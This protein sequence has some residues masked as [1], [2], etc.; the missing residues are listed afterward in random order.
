MEI[1]A[2]DDHLLIKETWP[3]LTDDKSEAYA[4]LVHRADLLD[5]L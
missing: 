3:V 2:G 5:T 4:R 1:I